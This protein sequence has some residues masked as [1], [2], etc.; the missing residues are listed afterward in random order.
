MLHRAYLAPAALAVLLVSGCS[1]PPHPI[2]ISDGT[3]TVDNRT[4]REWRNV[5]VTVNDHFSGGAPLIAPGGRLTA[6][7]GQLQTGHGQR[8][9]LARQTVTKVVV[10]ATDAAGEPVRLTWPE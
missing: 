6:P 9:S 7:L 10:T 2:A 4:D 3:L 5:R 8:F 1:A